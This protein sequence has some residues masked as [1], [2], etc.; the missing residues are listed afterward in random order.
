MDGMVSKIIQDLNG[1]HIL[2]VLNQNQSR[3]LLQ[4]FQ[5]EITNEIVGD[6]V[7]RRWDVEEEEVKIG[8]YI[9]SYQ[10]YAWVSA[11]HLLP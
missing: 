1:R 5:Y 6:R 10:I 3:E 7:V 11:I 8:V 4:G 9:R 2:V